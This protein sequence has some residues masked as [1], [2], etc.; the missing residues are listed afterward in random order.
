[1]NRLIIAPLAALAAFFMSTAQAQQMVTPQVPCAPRA[2][3]TATL[4]GEHGEEVAMRGLI[5]G[6]LFEIWR[7]EDGGFSATVT[8]PENNLTCLIASGSALH[9]VDPDNKKKGA[10]L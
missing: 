10:A 6:R 8:H 3:V 2:T 5:A 7:S 4:T 9:P 1:M